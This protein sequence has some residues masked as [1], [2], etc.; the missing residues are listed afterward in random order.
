MAPKPHARRT[1][2]R[3]AAGIARTGEPPWS[4]PLDSGLALEGHVDGTCSPQRGAPR[5]PSASN[6]HRKA[7]SASVRA[8]RTQW[9]D[10]ARPG[11]SH[12]EVA[13][14]GWQNAST[15]QRAGRGSRCPICGPAAAP[16][17]RRSC[18]TSSA[19]APDAPRDLG[20]AAGVQNLSPA[21]IASASSGTARSG[22]D[23]RDTV[24]RRSDRGRKL[25]ALLQGGDRASLDLPRHGGL[26][27][28]RHSLPRPS[29]HEVDRI[30]AAMGRGRGPWLDVRGPACQ[31]DFPGAST[32]IRTA[33][34]TR[35]PNGRGSRR[36][37]PS[38]DSACSGG[39]R[40]SEGSRARSADRNCASRPISSR[41][42]VGSALA[43]RGCKCASVACG[44]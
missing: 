16:P 7:R 13:V 23:P 20:T 5:P 4:G 9:T 1:A 17:R 30:D 26:W 21:S 42:R 40:S 37:D 8:E 39:H 3:I 18:C 24:S 15:R 11:R 10:C 27:Y 6:Q 38:G 25:T 35:C 44:R 32:T 22:P 14:P 28:V 19:G 36:F 41:Q 29:M 31:A 2:D 12:A 43:R 34:P 33:E